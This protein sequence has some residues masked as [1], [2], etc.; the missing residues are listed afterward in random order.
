[1]SKKL[2]QIS[3]LSALLIAIGSAVGAGIFFKN[4]TIF[5]NAGGSLAFMIASWV[6]AGFGILAIGLALIEVSSGAKTDGGILEWVKK[7]CPKWMSKFSNS[8]MVLVYLPLNYFALPIYAS[9]SIQDII[10]SIDPSITIPGWG[11]AGIAVGLFI[12]FATMGFFKMKWSEKFQWLLT[13]LQFLPLLIIPVLSIVGTVDSGVVTHV[14]KSATGLTG[15]SPWLGIMATI[16]AILFAVDGFYTV[17]ALKSNLKDEKKMGSIIAVAI[18]I[19]IALYLTF[20]ILLGLG[21]NTS[22]LDVKIL[23]D[24]PWLMAT[25][26][27]LILATLL[28]IVNGFSMATVNMYVDAHE[29]HV[30]APIK[31]TQSLMK[32]YFKKTDLRLSAWLTSIWITM[33]FFIVLIPIGIYAWS[34]NDYDWYG[35]SAANLYQL[36]DLIT[37]FTSMFVFMFIGAAIAGA[38]RNRK[39]NKVE[40]TKS[41]TWT[42]K[43]F[44]WD[45]K[46]SLFLISAWI[47]TIF[48]GV[49]A[50][51]MFIASIVDMSGLN[52]ADVKTSVVKFA[53]MLGTTLVA[54]APIAFEKISKKTNK[55]QISKAA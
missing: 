31:W 12:W 36:T 11:V 42:I 28:G 9:M 39:T 18:A 37:N 38:I 30:I 22:H 50:S 49:G 19:I 3:Y 21:G 24:N 27:T 41:K 7:F 13:G 14:S 10:Q 25:M 23:N 55:S 52:G 1:M 33:L 26:N 40:V 34:A 45:V 32:K 48:I 46:V 47:A 20:G 35:T 16:P 4:G 17:T 53:I 2:K 54:L 15:F 43:L 29:T 51:Y 8:Y 44:N 6:V 5:A